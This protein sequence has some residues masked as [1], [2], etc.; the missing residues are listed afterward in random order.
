MQ[1]IRHHCKYTMAAFNNTG[2]RLR[3]QNVALQWQAGVTSTVVFVAATART[4]PKWLIDNMAG[5]MGEVA[6]NWV[7]TTPGTAMLLTGAAG[8]MYLVYCWWGTRKEI[9]EA[10]EHGA[11]GKL[12]RGVFDAATEVRDEAALC[13][14]RAPI[15]PYMQRSA[16]VTAAKRAVDELAPLTASEDYEAARAQ[17]NQS[18]EKPDTDSFEA[19]FSRS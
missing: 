14:V 19:M 15:A 10:R 11:W 8:A 13:A 16:S 17:L 6:S 1:A 7:Q 5:P 18:W 4:A 12:Y 2:E 3:S 9:A